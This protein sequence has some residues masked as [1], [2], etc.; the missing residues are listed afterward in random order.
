LVII[1][2]WR[3]LRNWIVLEKMDKLK[4]DKVRCK[5][6]FDYYSFGVVCKYISGR[7]YNSILSEDNVFIYIELNSCHAT[8]SAQ[9]GMW[10]NKGNEKFCA[11][12]RFDEYFIDSKSYERKEKLRIIKERIEDE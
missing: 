4:R 1:I 2:G 10:F 6:D 7:I 9:N 11:I 12:P 3:S 5:E 8:L